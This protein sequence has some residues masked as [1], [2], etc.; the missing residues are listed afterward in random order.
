MYSQEGQGLQISEKERGQWAVYQT[1]PQ[2]F[3]MRFYSLAKQ[4]LGTLVNFDW[5]IHKVEFSN[6]STTKS[7]TSERVILCIIIGNVH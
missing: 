2:I 1:S 7:N 4:L 3:I 6:V 5:L